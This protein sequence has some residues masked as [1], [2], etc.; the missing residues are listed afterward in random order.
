MKRPNFFT[1]FLLLLSFVF[2]VQSTQSQIAITSGNAV[3]ANDLVESIIAE[4]VTYYN[5]QFVGH[6]SSK[7]IFSNGSSTNLGLDQGIFLS[8]GYAADLQGP[9]T[10]GNTSGDMGITAPPHPFIFP[11]AHDPA[12]LRFNVIPETDTFRLTYVFGS[13]EYNEWVVK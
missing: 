2:A 4:G 6:E 13:E 9:N 12:V 8:T 3:T 1:I 7:G 10:S 5:A 11:N